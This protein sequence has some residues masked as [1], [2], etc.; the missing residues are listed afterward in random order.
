V[1]IEELIREGKYEEAINQVTGNDENSRMIRAFILLKAGKFE[2]V[3]KELEG[4]NN[5]EAHYLRFEAYKG[6]GNSEN[7]IK[8]LEEVLKDRDYEHFLHYVLAEYLFTIKSYEKALI[9]IN[10]ALEIMPYNYDYKFLKA[11]I[12]FEQG[13]Y[14]DAS[15]YLTDVISMNPKNVEA[16]LLKALCYYNVGLKMDALSEINKALD[17]K[18]DDVLLHTLKAKI[19]FETRFYKLA[20]AEFKIAFRLN[21]ND[22]DLAYS[23]ATCYHLLSLNQDAEMFIDKAIAMKLKGEY[24][25]LKA[26]IRKALGDLS[27]AKEYALKAIK[28]DQKLRSQL[29]DLL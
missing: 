13:N 27:S 17:F 21:P 24:F 7:A 2:A 20:L 26:R 25:A 4:M 12:L 23:I 8:E 29:E 19:Y 1:D 11:K 22:P 6:L 9:H 10:K 5:T 3:L 15:I 14:E 28:L 18:K 16:R